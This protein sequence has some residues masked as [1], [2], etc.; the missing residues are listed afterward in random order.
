MKIFTKWDEY[1]DLKE[2]RTLIENAKLARQN[3]EKR[4]LNIILKQLVNE[5]FQW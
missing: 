4:S 5:E 2:M 1:Y 3:M